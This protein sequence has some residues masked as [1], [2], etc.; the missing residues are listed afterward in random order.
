MFL[1]KRMQPSLR[2]G[3]VKIRSGHCQCSEHPLADTVPRAIKVGEG[4]TAPRIDV[5]RLAVA[6]N[7]AI[8]ILDIKRQLLRRALIDRQCDRAPGFR[9]GDATHVN[10]SGLRVDISHG[11]DEKHRRVRHVPHKGQLAIT[12]SRV[13]LFRIDDL[14]KRIVSRRVRG[15]RLNP[16]ELDI[17]EN[18]ARLGGPL[19]TPLAL[20]A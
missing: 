19:L 20:V 12:Q 9:I 3:P 6:D 13:R 5:E 4:G 15:W 8:G 11:L 17:L 7:V 2:S 18:H 14:V 1:D 10:L 16:F